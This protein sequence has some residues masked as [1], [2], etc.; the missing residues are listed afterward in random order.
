[1]ASRFRG[2][3]RPTS[4]LG[5][6]SEC[7]LLDGLIGDIRRGESR[8]LVVRGEAGIGKTALLEYLVESAPDLK[9]VRAAGVESEMELAYASLHQL[10]VPMLER[11][12][13]LPAPQRQALEI[14]FGLSAGAAPDRFLVG[15]AVLSLFSE[16]AEARPLLC[17]VDDA[18]WLDQASSLTLAFVARRLLAEPVG[19]VF[20][21]REP[22]E[23]LQHVSEL[24][25]HGMRNGD[26]RALLSS[27]VRF[28]L[29]ERVRDRIIAETR[30]NPLALLELPRG[31]TATQ[32]AGGFGMLPAHALSGRIEESFVRQLETLSD[33]ARRLLLVAA[34]EPV[35]DPLLL[36]RASERL[37]IAASAVDAATDELL[38]LGERVT[39][40]HPLVRSAVYRSAAVQ[41]RR[42]VH[43]ALAQATDRDVDPDRRAWHLAAAA[44][45]PDEQ[46]A[47]ELER[48]AGR[49]QARGGL[50]AAAAFL[51][52]AV[53]LTGDSARRTDRAL[54]A[55]EASLQA[56]VFDVARRLLATAEVGPVDELQRARLDLLRAEAAYSESRGSEAPALLLRAAKT[57]DPLD[58][59]LASE[60]YLDAWSAALFA[61][62][63]ASTGSLHHVS[64]EALARP[65]PAGP[66]RP[67]DLLLQGF[68]LAFTD[69]RSTAA[70]VLERA[71]RGFAGKSATVEEVLRWGWLATAAAV[72]VWDYETC[73]T[74]A[75][76]GVRLARE[77]GAL[78]VLAVSANVLA[79]AMAL[80]G[81]SGSAASLIAEANGVT[82][83][84]GTL[85]APY[86]ALVLGGLQGREAEASAVIDATIHDATAGGQGTAVQYAHWARSILLNGLGRYQEA[87]AA[88]QEASD[89]TPELFVSVWARSEL[90][91]AAARSEDTARARSA[92][93]RL[94]E[95]TC[96]AETDWGLG[97]A[98]RAR[99]L[100]SE[101][102]TAERLYQDAI[103]R[104][105]RT[106]LR[107]D[108]ARAHLLY[109]EWLRRENR[110]VDARAQ[111]RA[112]DCQ[113]TSIGMEAFAERAR[114]E[115][116]ATGERIRKRTVETRDDLT[117]Q[118]RQIAQLARDGLSNPEIGARLFLSPRTVEWHLGKV[119]TKLGVRSRREL[120][121]ALPSSDSQLVPA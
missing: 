32:L 34:A 63:L 104:L 66:Q 39:F 96:A 33:D 5:R 120:A 23:E 118:E 16:V 72:M 78:T 6:A 61:G 84:T 12:P 31:L 114:K 58:P 86:G 27:A 42:A 41:E 109:G 38:A 71:A 50:A 62:R 29:D 19:L 3:G 60:T 106:R 36:L 37:G 13:G 2:P 47:L 10:C 94:A 82:E 89:D 91:E 116:L 9:V 74:V 25:V 112:A 99:A 56:G 51:Q 52:R 90:I 54:A 7:A 17:V 68:S 117:A 24:E 15:L 57:L 85:V 103:E 8:S 107:P 73:V 4:L 49:A 121:N 108:L 64:R 83:A 95:A 21:A 97:L 45:G 20:A 100:L 35:G 55:A 81:E 1:M 75:T 76:R 14:V 92:L 101:G 30:G 43:L 119:F 87:L 79:Q 26:A 69:G 115:L 67:S 65:R 93:D 77:S 105:G 46:V 59:R 102:E 110:R 18:Q 11:L 88:A 40:R 70:P 111:L 44:A 98:A 28:M 48:S 80:G 22:G 113:F 53:A